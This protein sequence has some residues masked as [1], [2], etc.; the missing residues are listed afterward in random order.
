MSTKLKTAKS[1]MNDFFSDV[2]WSNKANE[3]SIPWSIY[4]EGIQNWH[5]M[6]S[7]RNTPMCTKNP[8]IDYLIFHFFLQFQCLE[9]LIKDVSWH[10]FIIDLVLMSNVNEIRSTATDQF[11]LIATRCSGEQHP[12]RFF[13]TL[14]FTQVSLIVNLYLLWIHDEI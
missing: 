3:N 13:I 9:S 4:C 10:Q 2:G 1:S 6:R 5:R 7:D 8:R 12:I 11:L 14:L